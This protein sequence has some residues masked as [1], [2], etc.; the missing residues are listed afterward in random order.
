MIPLHGAMY[1]MMASR[2]LRRT[3]PLSLLALG[4][5]CRPS[6]PVSP[7]LLTELPRPLT[8][9]EQM[10]A[11]TGNS[12]SFD[13]LR[14][15]NLDQGQANV[16][17]SPLS[18]SMALGMTLNGAAGATADEMRRTLGFGNASQQ[19]IND[20]YSGLI[21]LLRGL[22]SRT[23]LRIA[24]SIFYRQGFPFEQSFLDTGKEY[25]DAEIRGLD[26]DAPASLKTIN[27][28]VSR[29]TNAKIP[30]ILDEIKPDDVMYLIN[31][32]YF[33]GTWRSRFDPKATA[34][35][36]FHAVGGSSQPMKLMHQ[37]SKLPYAETADFQ[38]VDLQYGN[39]AFSMTVI[40]PRPGRDVN[41]IVAGLTESDWSATS[42]A[43]HEA[44]VDLYLPKLRLEY[45]RTLND[46]LQALG[47]RLAFTTA[48]FTPMSPRGRE[49]FISMVKQ[50]TFVDIYEEGTEAAAATVVAVSVTSLPQSQLM[51]VDRPFVFAIRERFSGTILFV[52]KIV[53][54]PTMES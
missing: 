3:V 35:A 10:V 44:E 43:F 37:R 28:W 22:D 31:A 4:L 2:S 19:S 9:R 6:D 17:L 51:R 50:K 54:M 15:I 46:D 12:F 26:F 13:L 32:V 53:K 8:D 48:D 30:T 40:L 29:S 14:Q 34:D 38:A 16:F 21:G 20:G 27:D 24:N 45:E 1:P 33:K 5:A 25:F 42:A 18:A 41:A 36:Q 49:L 23:D 52:G 39:S 7:A 11:A 47:M